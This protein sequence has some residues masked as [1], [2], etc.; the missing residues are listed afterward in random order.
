MIAVPVGE[1]KNRLSEY[2]RLVR[3]GEEIL[4]TDHGEV[5]A[6]LRKPSRAAELEQNPFADLIRRGLARP[7]SRPHDPKLYRRFKPVLKGVT[8]Q[9]LLDEEREERDLP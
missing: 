6:E 7:P 4:V 8:A 3:A 1:L 9:Q 2:L 5:V